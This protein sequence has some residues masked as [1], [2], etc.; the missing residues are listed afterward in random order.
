MIPH[1][2]IYLGFRVRHP[3][4]MLPIPPP[5]VLCF[6]NIWCLPHWSSVSLE[7]CWAMA[8]TGRRPPWGKSGESSL[9]SS[10]P[11]W[12]IRIPGQI[13]RRPSLLPAILHLKERSSPSSHRLPSP[14]PSPRTH[15]TPR[16]WLWLTSDGLFPA[17]STALSTV[18]QHPRNTSAPPI[19]SF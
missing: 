18:H 19:R 9:P 17:A 7:L 10:S 5:K 16:W 15:Q 3:I 12:T 6:R 1:A 8:S 14:A 4:H 13:R 2:A 11:R